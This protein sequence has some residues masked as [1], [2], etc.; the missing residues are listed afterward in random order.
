MVKFYTNKLDFTFMALADAT[1]R[2]IIMRLAK[3]E[4]TVSELAEP[5]NISLPAISKHLRILEKA[6]LLTREKTGR[7]HR[8]RLNTEPMNDA[9]NWI[10]KYKK[11]WHEQFEALDEYLKESQ[12]KKEG[13]S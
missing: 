12:P 7:V 4:C 3:S 8:C 2:A 10:A 6:G 13:K 9:L 11:F 1:R 5:F